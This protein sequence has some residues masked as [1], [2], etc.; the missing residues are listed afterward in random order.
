MVLVCGT[1]SA[2]TDRTITIRMVDSKTGQPI[3]TS[4]IEVRIRASQTS[5]QT[6]G[7]P[8]LDV[9]PNRDGVGEATFPV[10]ASDIRVYAR[11]GMW[12]YVNCDC[13]KDRGPDRDHWYSISEIL[14]SGIAAPNRCNKRKAVAKPGEFVFFVRSMT[15]WEKMWE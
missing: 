5:A 4:E 11:D 12:S 3:T 6:V 15:F 14:T 9:R 2:Q 13:V 10:A 1:L 8:P 7:I